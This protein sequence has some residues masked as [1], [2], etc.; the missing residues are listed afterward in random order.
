MTILGVERVNGEK[1]TYFICN[2]VGNTCQE[3]HW[4]LSNFGIH[5]LCKLLKTMPKKLDC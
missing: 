3:K 1:T 2:V 4:L 5:K